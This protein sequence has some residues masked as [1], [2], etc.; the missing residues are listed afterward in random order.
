M[1]SRNRINAARISA[2]QARKLIME[3][4]DPESDYYDDTSSDFSEQETNSVLL[5]QGI[6]E[7]DDIGCILSTAELSEAQQSSTEDAEV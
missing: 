6:S 3:S 4:I 5:D 1:A 2:E 7:C